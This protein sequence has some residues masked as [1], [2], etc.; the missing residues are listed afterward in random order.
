MLLA[1]SYFFSF[2][3]SSQALYLCFHG[4]S[5]LCVPAFCSANGLLSY[6]KYISMAGNESMKFRVVFGVECAPESMFREVCMID[7]EVVIA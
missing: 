5:S 4:F 1:F 2:P 3:F 7:V 6:F